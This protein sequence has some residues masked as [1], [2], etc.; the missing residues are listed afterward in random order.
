MD[1]FVEAIAGRLDEA[2]QLSLVLVGD[3]VTLPAIRQLVQE[4]GLADRILM[5]GRI[6]HEDIA[7][8][9]ACMDY[10]VLPDSNAYGSPMKLFEFMAMGVAMVAPDYAPIAEVVSD[11]HSGWL[12][13]R[14]DLAVC[15]QRV[16]DL[17]AREDER[18]RV[19][20]AARDYIVRERQ[21]RNNVEQ[22]LALLPEGVPR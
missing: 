1:S 3:G 19:G 11:G 12:F 2:P 14:G 18:S 20:A 5:P 21:W 10:A 9:I 4:R 13:P 16:L 7:S 6:A 8:W 15:V 22:M 17:A